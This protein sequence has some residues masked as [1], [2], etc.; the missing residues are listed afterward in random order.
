MARV[1]V[2]SIQIMLLRIV[3]LYFNFLTSLN[4]VF[5]FLLDIITKSCSKLLIK[6]EQKSDC[7]NIQTSDPLACQLTQFCWS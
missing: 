1:C 2:L 7:E 6:T 3:M 5:Y 4:T